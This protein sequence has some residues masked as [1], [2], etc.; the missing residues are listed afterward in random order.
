[1]DAQ[2]AC[3][4]DV[5]GDSFGLH[6]E[7]FEERRFGDVG[8]LGPVVDLAGSAGDLVP[9]VV[10]FGHVAVQTA[11]GFRVHRFFQQRVHFFGGRPDVAEVNILAA[12][13][14]ANRLGHQ[15]FEHGAGDCV[16]NDQRWAGEEVG[17]DVGVNARF[18]VAVA[19][20]HSGADQIVLDDG[21]VDR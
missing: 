12:F 10:V 4:A 16:G 5:A 19:G 2:C 1:E 13:T 6:L 21:F 18:K 7:A 9:Q 17:F 14:F 3:T 20:Q 11:I 15:V 8:G